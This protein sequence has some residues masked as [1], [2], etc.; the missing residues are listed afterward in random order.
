MGIFLLLTAL[1]VHCSLCGYEGHNKSTCRHQAPAKEASA[2]LALGGMTGL[3]GMP[4]TMMPIVMPGIVPH[5]GAHHA[6]AP[7]LLEMTQELP[8]MHPMHEL[9]HSSQHGF[10]F[11]HGVEGFPS[12]PAGMD[13]ELAHA[14]LHL[15]HPARHSQSGLHVHQPH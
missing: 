7:H 12:M 13:D 5:A 10:G 9:Q 4:M 1:Q 2:P 11:L 8:E 3:G 14:P 6:G 15:L